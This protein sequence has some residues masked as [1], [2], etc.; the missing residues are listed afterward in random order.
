MP[1]R[2]K[3]R[4]EPWP[5]PGASD[6]HSVTGDVRV[7]RGVSGYGLEPRD[8]FVWLPP[9]YEISRR[10]YPVLYMQDGQNVFDN[11]LSYAGE[12]GADEAATA[13][14]G[15]GLPCIVVGVP[16]AGKDRMSEY[17]P[18]T[19]SSAR[20]GTVE[21]RGAAYLAFL[22][23]TVRGLVNL[24]FRTLTEPERTGIAGSS[25]GGLISAYAS[26]AHPDVFGYCVAMSPALW[27]SFGEIFD[28]A[29]RPRARRARFYIDIGAQEGRWRAGGGVSSLVRDARK[30][31]D[32]LLEAGHV[33]AC[34]EDAE[35]RHT[36]ADW[37]R[38][39]PAALEWFLSP[40]AR[41]D[42]ATGFKHRLGD[43]W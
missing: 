20:F 41:P 35:G 31:R 17:S 21:G 12:W 24:S 32:T 5:P 43:V 19:R 42:G 29:A 40:S 10:R 36:E 11:A 37:R 9:D 3:T 34:I 39:F 38:R 2:A 16:N 4:W 30:L 7:L 28:F 18:W 22:Q 27:F 14:A 23:N 8:V 6:A 15:R 26:L 25:L 33:V 1:T 13:L